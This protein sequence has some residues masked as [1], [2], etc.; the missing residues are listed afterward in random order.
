MSRLFAEGM[1][2]ISETDMLVN[3]E[4]IIPTNI[5]RKCL[6]EKLFLSRIHSIITSSVWNRNVAMPMLITDIKS[7]AY[8]IELTGADPSPDF[9]ENAT[10]R[11][12]R[13]NPNM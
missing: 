13:Y 11:V 4:N 5:C 9:I 10:P 12:I 8:G 3:I 1:M 2:F 6:W 7:I